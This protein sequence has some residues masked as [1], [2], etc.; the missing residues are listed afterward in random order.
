MEERAWF[1]TAGVWRGGDKRACVG[2]DSAREKR[3]QGKTRLLKICWELFLGAREEIPV[4]FTGIDTTK[5]RKE[6]KKKKGR[7][8]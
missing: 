6:K 8:S 7:K 3:S 5:S 1:N 4:K 2:G